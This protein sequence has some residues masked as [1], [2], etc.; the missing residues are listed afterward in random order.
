[1]SEKSEKSTVVL[2]LK[3][4][5]DTSWRMFVPTIGLTVL[6]IVADRHFLTTPWATIVGICI[7]VVI[8][9]ILVCR[10]LK[11]LQKK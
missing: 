8:A 4:V 11:T 3:D 9:T 5:G 1:M 6:G 7:G 2:L 10:Q